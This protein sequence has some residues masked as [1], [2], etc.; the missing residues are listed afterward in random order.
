VPGQPFYPGV[1]IDVGWGASR[2]AGEALEAW[3]KRLCDAAHTFRAG[4]P[5]G[6]PLAPLGSP[7]CFLL[8][9]IGIGEDPLHAADEEG[10]RGRRRGHRSSGCSTAGPGYSSRTSLSGSPP[11]A[12][13]WSPSA[14]QATPTALT[15]HVFYRS[16]GIRHIRRRR[17]GARRGYFGIRVRRHAEF[18]VEGVERVDVGA[19][20]GK[21]G[22]RQP[23]QPWS[24]LSYSFWRRLAKTVASI[25]WSTFGRDQIL[26]PLVAYEMRRQ[27]RN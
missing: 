10:A 25:G 14:V 11:A 8:A 18:V 7:R 23:E 2:V 16:A 4:S 9:V 24:P 20:S 19:P 27:E 17:H 26:P 22:E 6:V 21:A 1:G 12:F 5:S 15:T 3:L 13:A